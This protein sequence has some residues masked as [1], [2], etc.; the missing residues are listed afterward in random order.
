[1][2]FCIIPKGKFLLHDKSKL[3][4]GVDYLKPWKTDNTQTHWKE[5]KICFVVKWIWTKEPFFLMLTTL[6]S[7]VSQV[8]WVVNNSGDIKRCGFDP[9]VRKIPL[10]KGNPLQYSCLENPLDRG[11][12]QATVHAVPVRQDWSHLACTHA[13]LKSQGVLQYGEP[14]ISFNLTRHS[15]G[16]LTFL[17]CQLKTK[18]SKWEYL[19]R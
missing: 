9:W 15:V 18:R 10:E 5:R 4:L 16:I 1:M 2:L 14:I 13:L 17:N 7:W 8:P 3:F 6:L 11:A 19:K 12:W